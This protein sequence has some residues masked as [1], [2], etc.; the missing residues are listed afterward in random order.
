MRLNEVADLLR[1]QG[2]SPFRVQAYRRGA[3]TVRRLA[4]RSTRFSRQKATR[5]CAHCPASATGWRSRFATSC[6]S[7][8]FRCWIVC[9]GNPIQW[10]CCKPFRESARCTPNV[11]TMTWASILW[12]TW[13]PRRTM[14]GWPTSRVSATSASPGSRIRSRRGW[15]GFVRRRPQNRT[16]RSVADLLDVDR[17]Y[18]ELAAAG[19]L[20]QIAPRRFNPSGEAWL[21]ILHT[22]RGDRHYTALFS[23]TARAHK[24]GKTGDWVILYY[25]GA[26]GERQ[27]TVITSQ[28]GALKGRRI[29]RGREEECARYYGARLASRQWPVRRFL[30]M[31]ATEIMLT[32][33]VLRRRHP[34]DRR[35]AGLP[36]AA[37]FDRR[38]ALRAARRSVAW[39]ARV[40]SGARADHQ[41]V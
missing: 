2:A 24:L 28:F 37:R 34:T 4:G 38:R 8:G 39:H 32:D 6:G 20:H 5:D 21:P 25:D 12:K 7:G 11:C 30:I 29:V 9:A 40:L 35:A 31:N 17:E 10:S 19:R 16:R 13:K 27:A 3:E 22:Q 14:D 23:N 18:R 26:G 33:L 41:A 1:E 36:A 15:A